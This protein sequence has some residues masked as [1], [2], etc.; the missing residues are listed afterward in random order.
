MCVVCE[1]VC[2]RP[3]ADVNQLNQM[4]NGYL[5][6]SFPIIINTFGWDFYRVSK[7]GNGF[8]VFN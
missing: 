4:K 5:K 3:F 2:M 7:S 6:I 8:Y 1:S